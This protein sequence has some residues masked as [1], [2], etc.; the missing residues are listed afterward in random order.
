[1]S[2]LVTGGSTAA[3][4]ARMVREGEASARELTE[5]ALARIAQ[6]DPQLGAFRT[7][8]AEAALVEADKRDA[9][10]AAGEDRPL[11]GVPI[12][13]KDETDVAGVVTGLGGN[14]VDAPAAAD[15]EVVRRLRAAGAV[16]VGKTNLPEFGQWPFTESA[17]VGYTRN[18]WDPQRSAGGSSGGSAVAVASGMVPLALG[19][20]GGGSIRIPAACCGLFGLKTQ[21]GRNSTAPWPD[22]WKSLAV[23]GP[24]AR[25]VLDAAAFGDAMRGNVE[26]DVYRWPEPRIGF[27]DAA[28]SEPG[29]LRV[30]LS[31]KPAILGVRLDPQ[32]RA[33]LHATADALV[34][35]GHEVVSQELPTSYPMLSFVPQNSFGLLEQSRAVDHPERLERCTKQNLT[36]A[37]LMPQIALDRALHYGQQLAERME[38]LFDRYDL[39]LQP[40]IAALPRPLGALDGVTAIEASLRSLPYIAYTVL[41][42]VTGHPAAAVPAGF[43]NEG[44]PLSVQ[45]IAAQGD[46]PTILQAA[47][48]LERERPW[49]AAVPLVWAFAD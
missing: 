42:N 38:R 45:L 20:D 12:A 43:S 13:I 41:W 22:A 4:Q 15:A 1:M 29:R 34:S 44:L 27:T 25:T 19:S 6:L 8:I 39:I 40:T 23:T 48:Q 49:A 36:T 17:A 32:Q 11:L 2:E 3:D 37:K 18:P 30:M 28:L 9:Q 10:H 46:E 16:I 14:T 26:S 33:A 31:E 21:R 35:L 5:Q 47:A 24:I 7:I